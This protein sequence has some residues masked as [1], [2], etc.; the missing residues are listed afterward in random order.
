M[1]YSPFPIV[2]LLM[3]VGSGAAH[4]TDISG[5]IS[6]TLTIFEDSQLAGDVTCT[7]SGASCI[8]FGASDIKLHLNGHT[9]TGNGVRGSCPSGVVRGEDGINT[10]FKDHVS[11]EGPGLIRRFR[12]MGIV[13]V[14]NDSEV[15]DVV[16]ASSCRD[17][18]SVF[19]SHN[20]VEESTVIR[21]S[22]GGGFFAGIVCAGGGGHR[23]RRNEVVGAGPATLIGSGPA[24]LSGGGT[25]IFIASND[26]LIEK[27]DISGNPGAGIFVS[28]PS[29]GAVTG[30]V[31]RRNR[32]LGNVIFD[33]IFDGNASGSNT[34]KGNL[35]E[36]SRIGS[37]PVSICA[38]SAES[39]R[40]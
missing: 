32:A 11:I 16:V 20:K 21:A 33:D 38:S 37:P 14:G 15:K 9:V 34:Y 4:A 22:L 40:N 8:V 5:T 39:V 28:T 35:C 2:G 18:I 10:D 6:S 36:V 1:K 24:V 13:V 19:G 3:V 12:E 7:V 29:V 26:N 25:G 31:I 23:I 17:G 30:N 27:N